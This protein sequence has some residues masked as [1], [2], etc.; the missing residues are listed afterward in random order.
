MLSL[1][2]WK[3]SR[4]VLQASL[5]FFAIILVLQHKYGWGAHGVGRRVGICL[6][7]GNNIQYLVNTSLKCNL[8]VS[9]ADPLVRLQGGILDVNKKIEGFGV[10]DAYVP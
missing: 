8:S 7:C 4:R 1:W 6:W 9:V 2:G 10:Q 5:R 3:V